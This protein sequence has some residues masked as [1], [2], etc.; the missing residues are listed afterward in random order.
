MEVYLTDS[1]TPTL[2]TIPSLVEAREQIREIRGRGWRRRLYVT[3]LLLMLVS[4]VGTGL[5]LLGVH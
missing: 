4:L 1:K 2:E 3:S 5:T